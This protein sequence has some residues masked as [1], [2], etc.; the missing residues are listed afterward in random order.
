M[1]TKG[2]EKEDINITIK[3]EM[4]GKRKTYL[5]KRTENDK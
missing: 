3:R 4:E 2:V 5:V 1:I